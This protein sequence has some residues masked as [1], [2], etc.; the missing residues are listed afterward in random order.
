MVIVVGS[1]W[2]P[3][4]VVVDRL[5]E[6]VRA[7]CSVRAAAG[8]LGLSLSVAYRLA[9]EYALPLQKENT[10]TVVGSRGY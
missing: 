6:L 2:D 1:L 5:C 4:Q 3:E 8:E 7:G 10:S 9:H